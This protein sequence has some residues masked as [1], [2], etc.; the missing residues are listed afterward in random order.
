M[1]SEHSWHVD[2]G[3]AR[4]ELKRFCATVEVANPGG[5]L[6]HVMVDGQSLKDID[7]LGVDLPGQPMSL[8]GVEHYARGGDLI[9]TYD[10]TPQRRL[11]AQIYWRA[12]PRESHSVIAAIEL[13]ASVQ[14]SLLDACPRLT[15]RSTVAAREAFRL[16]DAKRGAFE[17]I[18]ALE[19]N[20]A[21]LPTCF[22]F[23]LKS[24][25][26]SFVEMVAPN[27]VQTTQLAADQSEDP[28]PPA[29]LVHQL[30]AERLEKGVI[31]RARVLGVLVDRDGD[32]AAAARHYENFVSAAPPLTT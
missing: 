11:R 9:A 17:L 32:L 4:L 19:D 16:V 25:Q 24:K 18:P 30:F 12:A 20:R 5:G 23:R 2:L 10:E 29:R 7:L 22:V 26:I 15:T 28:A 6:R 27:V 1:A 14:T 13:V 21:D 31:L 3:G 8:T